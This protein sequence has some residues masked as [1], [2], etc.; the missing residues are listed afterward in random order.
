M[1]ADV[2]DN[3]RREVL[4]H[5]ETCEACGDLRRLHEELEG[6]TI[7]EPQETELLQIRRG[8]LRSLRSEAA[9]GGF[10]GQWEWLPLPMLRP[11]LVAL[12]M[13]VLLGVGFA[14]GRIGSQ[15]GNGASAITGSIERVAARNLQLAQSQDSPYSYSNVRLREVDS[16]T[17]RLRFDVATHLDLVRAKDDPLVAEVLVQS[18][19]NPA[20]VGTSLEAIDLVGSL[21]PKVRD[22]LVVAMLEDESLAVRLKAISKLTANDSDVATQEALLEVLRSEASVTMR[23][24]A[25]DHLT[26]HEVPADALRR[27]LEEGWP[28]PG[29]AVYAKAE[30]YLR[31]F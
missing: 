22:A 9:A 12:S 30:E 20:S 19:V 24:L 2:S 6:T 26:T 7:P 11:A 28:E 31:V 10:R 1:S 16:Q 21:Q 13:V 4:Q 18:L 3:E 25:I 23:L 17:V 14:A 27:A 5:A 8:V 29:T 15:A